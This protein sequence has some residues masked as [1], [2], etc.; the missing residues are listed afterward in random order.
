MGETRQECG[1]HH[2]IGWGLGETKGGGSLRTQVLF[3]RLLPTLLFTV[4]LCLP[5]GPRQL[6][7]L[8]M[9]W[10]FSNSGKT[11]LSKQIFIKLLLSDILSLG[12]K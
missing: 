5:A 7:P 6:S 2:P 1:Q 11:G 12:G 8:L 3:L 9:G 10:N 4:K